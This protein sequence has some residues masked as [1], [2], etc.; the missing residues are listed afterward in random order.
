MSIFYPPGQEKIFAV[1]LVFG[2]VM[3]VLFDMFKIKRRL[4]GNSVPVIF[5]DDLIFS[6]VSVIAFLFT[7]FVANN[8]IFRWFEVFFAALGFC[9]YRLTLSKFVLIVFYKII[10]LFL[11]AVRRTLQ[12]IFYPVKCLLNLLYVALLP[13]LYVFI[14]S[15]NKKRITNCFDKLTSIRKCKE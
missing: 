7:V 8:G 12:I 11:F 5:L 15:L 13:F 10:D 9:L 14:R 3:G 4:L 1:M 6:L 2:A